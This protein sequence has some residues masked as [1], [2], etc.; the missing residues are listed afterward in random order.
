MKPKK[1]SAAVILL[2]IV[3]A[4]PITLILVKHQQD[5]RSNAAAP[6]KLEAEGGVLGGNAKAQTDSLA[7]GGRYIALGINPTPTPIAQPGTVYNVP[8]TIDK[9]GSTVVS[10]QINS[11]ISSLPNGT[12]SNPTIAEFAPGT[13]KLGPSGAINIDNKSFIYLSGYGVTIRA[14]GGSGIDDSA[15]KIGSNTPS[16]DIK[17]YGFNIIGANPDGATERAYHRG[18]ESQ[19]GFQLSSNIGNYNVEIYDNTISDVYGHAIYIRSNNAPFPN[20]INFH[21]NIIRRTGVMGVAIVNGTN[22][23]IKSNLV[24]DTPLYPIN[25]ED[26][27]ADQPVQH[28]Y[29]LDNTINRW[30]WDPTY[31]A[32]AISAEESTGLIWDDVVVDGNKLQG[33]DAGATN[34]TN[35]T[36]GP[37][38][39]WGG[40]LKKN[41]KITNNVSS[42]PVDG[43]ASRFN[44]VSGLIIQHNTFPGIAGGST[45][46]VAHITNSTNVTNGPN[47]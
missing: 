43:W 47:P 27:I 3:L 10:S 46:E 8:S 9:T 29:I 25:I 36:S 33:G 14:T 20:N 31:T 15:I 6:D 44:N 16:H 34:T 32:H 5:N 41:L 22:I 21:N 4:L 28:I 2:L 13:Y 37:I 11:W 18:A 26:G 1:I 30:G 17:A 19:Q 42:V 7:S 23:T 35:S 40:D 12:A 45:D 24:E 38:S 39:F